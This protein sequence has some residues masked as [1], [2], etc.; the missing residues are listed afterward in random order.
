MSAKKIEMAI[1]AYVRVVQGTQPGISSSQHAN[2][3]KSKGSVINSS[4]GGGDP[5]LMV[6]LR[7][8]QSED[9]KA[10]CE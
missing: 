4:T 5:D 1:G 3:F 2:R 8:K 9:R 7:E 6:H 10:R